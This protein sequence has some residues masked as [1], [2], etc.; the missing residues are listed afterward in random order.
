MA[1]TF[2]E[3]EISNLEK[4]LQRIFAMNIMRTTFR[5]VQ[6]L[7]FSSTNGDKEQ[8][9]ILFESLLNGEAKLGPLPKAIQDR[10]EKII[11]HYTIPIRLSKEIFE[12]GDCISV[13][14]SDLLKQGENVAFINRIRR[15]DG[16]EFQ[17]LSEPESTLNLLRHF[18]ARMQDLINADK[19]G[20][21]AKR[22]QL[23]LAEMREKIDE[24]IL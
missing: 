8:A 5:E 7:V 9:R 24:M 12:K 2:T 13:I 15:V 10:M 18:L 1:A 22:I 21:F 14:T 3:K 11:D 16:E 20:D 6:N 19:E 17:F 4:N 23:P